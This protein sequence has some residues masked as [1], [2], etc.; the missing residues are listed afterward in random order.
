MSPDT[1]TA[2][3]A[4]GIQVRLLSNRKDVFAAYLDGNGPSTLILDLPPGVYR[5]EWVNTETG[6]TT[7]IP[8]LTAAQNH[9]KIATPAFT[10]GM[11]LQLR[12][13]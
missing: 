13:Q 3:H 12:R 9:T 4:G 8:A 1:R 2:V 10:G 5:G 6:A 11:A 7:S